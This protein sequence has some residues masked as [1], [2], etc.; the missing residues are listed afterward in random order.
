MPPTILDLFIA[1]FGQSLLMVGAAGLLAALLGLPLGLLLHAGDRALSNT[2]SSGRMF[3]VVCAA[4]RSGP[5]VMAL[6]IAAPLAQ[7]ALSGEAGLGAAIASLTV[8]ATPFLAL[9]V[10]NALNAADRRDMETA[11]RQGAA[12]QQLLFAAPL[13][14]AFPAIVRALG[15]MLAA[16]VGYSSIAGAL[17]GLGL[18]DLALRQ[19]YQQFQPMVMLSAAVALVALAETAQAMGNLLAARLQKG[20]GIARRSAAHRLPPR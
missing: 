6:A 16:L 13:P 20:P 14:Q 17:L 5:V 1:A 19:G 10:R 4:L 9:R 3:A 15:L 2:L 7:H 11:R 18:G 12:K 8:I